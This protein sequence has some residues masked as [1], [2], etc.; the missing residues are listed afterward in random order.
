MPWFS[1]L[2]RFGDAHYVYSQAADRSCGIASVMM[3]VYKVNKF[4]PFATATTQEQEVYDVYE[5]VSGSPYDGST[6]TN[7]TLLDNALNRL[8]CG[9]WK[10][11][12]VGPNGVSQ[13]IMDVVGTSVGFGPTLRTNPIIVL[14]RWSNGGHFVVV[15]SVRTIVGY[16]T[17]A[18]VCDPWDAQ[19]RVINFSAGSPFQY[20]THDTM[21][22]NIEG[23]PQHTYGG[24]QNGT[25]NGWVV[26]RT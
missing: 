22:L 21:Q 5:Q 14:I 13:K 4:N 6:N 16:N 17:W 26:Y 23:T 8:N 18:T 2:T 7:A 10:A 1:R 11:E 20:T 12:N 9:K 19:L 3:C 15:D 25:A 24:T